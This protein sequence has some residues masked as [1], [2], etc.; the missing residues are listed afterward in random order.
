MMVITI[1]WLVR[2][3]ILS[4][5]LGQGPAQLPLNKTSALLGKN[6]LHQ[7]MTP[8]QVQKTMRLDKYQWFFGGFAGDY[9]FSSFR[10]ANDDFT[11]T[12]EFHFNSCK[13]GLEFR[14]IE[15]K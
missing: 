7:G 6:F 15:I 12:V 2:A 14:S 1:A 3:A 4:I 11:I 9:W 13:R 5:V 8:E 10:S